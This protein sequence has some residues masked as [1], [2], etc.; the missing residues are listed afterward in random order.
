MHRRNDGGGGNTAELLSIPLTSIE[1]RAIRHAFLCATGFLIL[2]PLGVLCARYARTFTSRWFWGHTAIQA[3]ISGPV[4]IAGWTMGHNLAH[5]L[6][7]EI[8]QDPHGKIGTALFSMYLTQLLLGTVIHFVKM[9]GI[10]RGHRSP[11]NYLHIAL[12][13]AIIA[14]AGYQVHYGFTIIWPLATGNVHPVP[15]SAKHAWLALIIVRSFSPRSNI[16]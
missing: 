5:D 8:S 3:V 7:V 4:I 15:N 14:L 16:R 2:L 12:G 13:L 9:Q 1:H 6:G 11:Q 10:F